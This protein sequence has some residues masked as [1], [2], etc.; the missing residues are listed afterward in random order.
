M[1]ATREGQ[2]I[3]VHAN[4]GISL[5]IDGGTYVHVEIKEHYAHLRHFAGQLLQMV[6][7]AEKEALAELEVVEEVVE[8]AEELGG[9]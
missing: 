9:D 3:T 6:E 5:V 8:V 1:H 4:C 7:A 2:Q